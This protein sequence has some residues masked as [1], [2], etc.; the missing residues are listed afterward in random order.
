MKDQTLFVVG[1]GA[2]AGGLDALQTFFA[3]VPESSGLAFVVVQHLSPDYE[4]LM[5]EL[6]SKHTPMRVVRAEE[7]VEVQADHV[8]LIPPKKILRINGGRL[9]LTEMVRKNKVNLPIDVFFRALAEDQ[10]EHAVGIIL[11]GTGSDGTQ[12]VQAI[13]E[14]AGMIMVQAQDSAKFDGMPRSAIST[15]VADYILPPEEMPGELLRYV[16]HHGVIVTQDVPLISERSDEFAQILLELKREVGINF[17]EYKIGTV[18][19]RIER[20]L[21]VQHIQQLEDYL[22]FLRSASHE[23]R[24]L[25]ADL[26]IGVTQFFRTTEAFDKLQEEV[27]PRLLRESNHTVRVWVPGCSTGEEAYSIGILLLEAMERLQL[28]RELQIF[29]TDVDSK[30]IE[31][32]SQGRYPESIAGQVNTDLLGRYFKHVDGRYVVTRQLREVIVFATQN[33]L[34]DPP[35]TRLDL[36][37]CRNL[38]IYFK[39]EVQHKVLNLFAFGLRKDGFLF[40]GNSETIGE[41]S[42]EF[43]PFDAAS[44]IY[45]ARNHSLSTIEAHRTLPSIRPHTRPSLEQIPDIRDRT[46]QRLF[47]Y[48]SQTFAP[49]GVALNEKLEPIHVFGDISRFFRLA[50]GR[51]SLNILSMAREELAVLIATGLGKLRREGAPLTY[52]NVRLRSDPEQSYTLRMRKLPDEKHQAEITLLFIEVEAPV[53]AKEGDGEE[54]VVRFDEEISARMRDL[55]MELQYTRESLQATIEELETSNEE[56]QATNEELVALN[57]ELQATNEELQSLNEELH[58][59]NSEYQNKILELSQLNDDLDNL[60]Q[61]NR[62]AT[63]FLDHDLRIRKFT[64]SAAKLIRLLPHDMGRPLSDLAL[65]PFPKDLTVQLEGVIQTGR[66]HEV[67]FH[68]DGRWYLLR[69]IPFVARNEEI[70]GA[71]LTLI[72]VHRVREALSAQARLEGLVDQWGSLA[73]EADLPELIRLEHELIESMMSLS[74][75]AIAFIDPDGRVTMAN[76]AAARLLG[77]EDAAWDDPARPYTPPDWQL[78]AMDDAQGGAAS[79][80]MQAIEARKPVITRQAIRREDGTRVPLKMLAVPCFKSSGALYRVV[81]RLSPLPP[82]DKAHEP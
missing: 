51:L 77:V 82:E 76:P 38:L 25:A 63:V 10:G 30:A 65:A 64:P 4:S 72:D 15:G 69:L 16:R 42:S 58:T 79:P 74:A 22:T 8:Y 3:H 31:L 35:F 9:Q 61:S 1:I 28:F 59:V 53:E 40:L 48:I 66:E 71:L 73:Q 19:R 57:E 67:E 54:S 55:E 46:Q 7:G 32:A 43:V 52:R 44:K 34:K 29:A 21:R 5:V 11:S 41:M 27:I 81:C 80:L 37:S 68:L 18:R 50:P 47:G 24:T 75:E 6:L 39:P 17:Q 14:A 36:I 70:T 56:L 26:L 20:R 45:R 49:A 12:G 62:I 33:L 78:E 23:R 60:L 2:S 13:K